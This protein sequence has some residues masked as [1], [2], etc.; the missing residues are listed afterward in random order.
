[1]KNTVYGRYLYALGGNR[2]S[3]QRIL[4]SERRYWWGAFAISGFYV[5]ADRIAAARAG[6]AAAS[7]ASAIPIFS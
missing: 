6:A 7:S 4:I 2:T 1:M 5:R 3:A